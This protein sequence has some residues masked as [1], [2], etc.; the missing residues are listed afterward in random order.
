MRI[1][2]FCQYFFPE[3]FK[4]NE[5]CTQLVNDGHSVTVVTG[6]PNYPS[7]KVP[8]EYIWGRRREDLA[9]V[10]VIRCF[11]FGR[12]RGIL[13]L[14]LN[15]ISY[16]LSASWRTLFLDKNYDIVFVYQLS[17][18]TMALPAVIM[19]ARCRK[20]LYLYCCDI[21]PESLKNLIADESSM[22]F[23]IAGVAS[24]F[25]YSKCDMIT[26]TSKPFIE[27]LHKEHCILPSRITYVPQ[28]GDDQLLEQELF[29]DNGV[30]D[31]VFMGNIGIAQDTKCVVDAVDQIRQVPGFMLHFVGAGSALESTKALVR[32]RGLEN[33][34]I[35]HGRHPKERMVEFYR[36]ADAC[37]ITL[38]SDT[39][40]GL[41]MPA[42]LQGYMAAG[43]A[44]I[45]AINGAAKQ[46]IE[47]SGCGLCV[48]A[49]DASAL[50]SAI[51]EFVTNPS[52]YVDCGRKG[53]DYYKQNFTKQRFMGRVEAQLQQLVEVSR[54][55]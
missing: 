4:I 47:E 45:G 22:L 6:L 54:G 8:S 17:P 27:Y 10:R 42:K 25:L 52:G 21:W 5:I 24:R 11:E 23:R 14:A 39:Q 13:G 44:V 37:L 3:Q 55:V 18:V 20:P 12:R 1:L 40:V 15:Y 9:G 53:R 32:Q 19:K 50:A 36:L 51:R 43:K 49:G 26:V 33:L 7:G 28:H 30:F 31:I 38:R 2:V 46:V 29:S 34:I 16:M 41:T 35:F 48:P